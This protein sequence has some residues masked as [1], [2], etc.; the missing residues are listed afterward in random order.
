MIKVLVVDD[1]AFMRKLLSDMFVETPDFTVVDTARNGLEAIEKI[2]KLNPDIVTLDVEMP[3][4][5]GLD[6]LEVIMQE[7]PLPVVMISTF[8]KEGSEETI[9]ALFHGAVDFVTKNNN[10]INSIR[11]TILATCR[12]AA[13]AN[14]KELGKKSVI[15][16]IQK[17]VAL[18]IISKKSGKIVVIGTSTGGPRALQEIIPK[19]PGNLPCGVVVVQHMP[20]GF[21]KSLAD[22]L[23]YLSPIKVKEAEHNEPVLPSTV[24]IAPGEYHIKFSNT[25][26]KTIINLTKDPPI[27]GHRPAVDPM[28]ESAAS[29]YGKECIAVLLT[30]MGQDGAAGMLA[31]KN[32]NGYTIAEDQ[33]T[34]IVYGMP[35]AAAE[36]GAV[37]KVLPLQE[38]AAEIV[39]AVLQ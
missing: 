19:L 25:H 32:K 10:D 4:M 6:A 29:V 2:K 28:F 18:N 14:I 31:I 26:E 1:S 3:I 24:Y 7:H 5:N 17:D 9:K 22:R 27:A 30:G 13:S 21:T 33:K 37:L 16:N 11:K 12:N 8:T 38:I 15:K 39:R 20:P 34:A 23:D 35:K 36:R